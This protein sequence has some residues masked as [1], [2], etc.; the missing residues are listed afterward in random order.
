MQ[1]S[2]KIV[3]KAS[4]RNED[5]EFLVAHRSPDEEFFPDMW[6]FPGG[7]VEVNE[8]P[9]EAIRREVLEEVALD[10]ETA[11]EMAK[12]NW[13]EKGVPLEFVAFDVA[14]IPGNVTIN[15]DEYTEFKW[16]SMAEVL[17]SKHTLFLDMYF[18]EF[19]DA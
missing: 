6:D 8:T 14:T 11:E 3:V 17:E 7:R 1:D 13:T 2:S 5:G 10:V 9:E 16:A 12:Y 18:M 15:L 4:I 19:P